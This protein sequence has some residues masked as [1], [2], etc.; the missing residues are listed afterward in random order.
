MWWIKT[1]MTIH[2][3]FKFIGII[4]SKQW[5]IRHLTC[6]DYTLYSTRIK[7]SIKKTFLRGAA[8]HKAIHALLHKIHDEMMPNLKMN[9]R[10]I[11]RKGLHVSPERCA[12]AYCLYNTNT[13][14]NE[15]EREIMV[16]CIGKLCHC[17]SIYMCIYTYG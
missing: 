4:S 15:G 10:G 5:H 11:Y 1:L 12:R 6:I 16:R 3:C 9:S 14:E 8:Y 17:Y 7:S 2:N 13:A